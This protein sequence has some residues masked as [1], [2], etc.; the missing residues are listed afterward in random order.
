[1][2]LKHPYLNLMNILNSTSNDRS[3]STTS[4]DRDMTA[5]LPD[6]NFHEMVITSFVCQDMHYL[7]SR[8][9]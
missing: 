9:C 6:N 1:M 8:P 7:D 5:M 4:L 2:D 3:M